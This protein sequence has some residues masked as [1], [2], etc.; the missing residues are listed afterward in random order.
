MRHSIVAV[1]A[2]MMGFASAAQAVDVDGKWGVGAGLGNN[3]TD[4]TLIHGRSPS[5]AW[6]FDAELEQNEGSDKFH[7]EN[8]FFSSDQTVNHNFW[9]VDAG[10]GLR[11]YTRA[12]ADFSPYWDLFVHGMYEHEHIFITGSQ[13][14]TIYGAEA[15]AAIGLEYFTRWHFSVAAHTDV[16]T[17]QWLYRKQ[18]ENEGFGNSI[19]LTGHQQTA[20]VGISPRLFARVYF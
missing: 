14:L 12:S 10:P 2:M 7:Q 8:P 5:S 17:G 6:L 9:A 19:R 3:F 16:V 20:S 4:V 15:G 11:H 13:D 1:L 18:T